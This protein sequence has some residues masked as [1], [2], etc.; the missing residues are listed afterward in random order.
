MGTCLS[1][2]KIFG[3]KSYFNIIALS[4]ELPFCYVVAH[5]LFEDNDNTVVIIE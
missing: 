2:T 4:Y 1:K 3:T 5:T